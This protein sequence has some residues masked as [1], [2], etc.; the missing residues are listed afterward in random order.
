MGWLFLIHK[1]DNAYPCYELYQKTRRHKYDQTINTLS[2]IENIDMVLESRENAAKS[3]PCDV[4]SVNMNF[5]LI[6]RKIKIILWYQCYITKYLYIWPIS[7]C[8]LEYALDETPLF[9]EVLSHTTVP[10]CFIPD[11]LK[12]SLTAFSK[13]VV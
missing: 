8:I 11:V 5:L 10:M 2:H 6:V 1:I 13:P 3:I 4:F 7:L 12:Y 9:F